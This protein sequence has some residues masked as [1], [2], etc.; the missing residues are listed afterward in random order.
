MMDPLVYFIINLL[1]YRSD[2]GSL[3][4]E[5][6]QLLKLYG[7]KDLAIK[8]LARCM[9]IVN[10]ILVGTLWKVW[11]LSPYSIAFV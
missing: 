5:S 8:L 2:S 4:T 1:R 11:G 6:Q 3:I 7:Q 9:Y 10:V